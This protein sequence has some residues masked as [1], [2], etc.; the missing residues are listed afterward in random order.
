MNTHTNTCHNI[1][2]THKTGVSM[3][4]LGWCGDTVTGE[5]SPQLLPSFYLQEGDTRPGAGVTLCL[6]S[7]FQIYARM[8]G[9]C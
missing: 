7:P 5:C 8:L 3:S 4:A 6:I 1:K 2:M 9:Y